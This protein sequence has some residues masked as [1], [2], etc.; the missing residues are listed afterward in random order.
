MEADDINGRG[1]R[2][3]GVTDDTAA[4]QALLTRGGT[5]DLPAGTY[6]VAPGAANAPIM[7][8]PGPNLRIVGSGMGRTIIKVESGSLPYQSL[9]LAGTASGMHVE[10]I[11]FD[12]NVAGNPIA[13]AAELVSAPRFTLQA[14]GAGVEVRRCEIENASSVNDLVLSG[15]GRVQDCRW[16]NIGDDPNH[17]GH[18][19]ACIYTQAADRFHIIANDFV[20]ARP[21]APGARAAIEIH[22]SNHVVHGNTIK[23]FA[24][25][26]HLAGIALTACTNNVLANN[27]IEGAGYG[28]LIYSAPYYGHVTGYGVDGAVIEGNVISL[29]RAGTWSDSAGAVGGIVVDPS[30]TLDVRGLKIRGNVVRYPL[31]T[32]IVAANSVSCGIGWYS[33]AGKVFRASD[34]SGNTIIG[35][36]LAGIRLSCGVDDVRVTDNQLHNCGSTLD[37]A[38]VP[39]SYR[40]PVFLF[41]PEGSGA[42]LD[43]NRVTDTIAV[44]R[45]IYGYSLYTSGAS[46]IYAIDNACDV[47]GDGVAFLGST[48][49]GAGAQVLIRGLLQNGADITPA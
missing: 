29:A 8:V 25:G 28:V 24:H 47:T 9:F 30:A 35:F 39:V 5:V 4:L 20:G 32:E 18:D 27:M 46:R 41:I 11:T 44:T 16:T 37:V 17:V 15:S 6:V 38:H 12:H 40:T 33:V 7:I 42:F 34:I 48:H 36:P 10:G 3:D 23:D 31:E 22:G 1:L 14:T 45:N 26:I 21:G 19:S 13:N 43:R 49:L 2:G